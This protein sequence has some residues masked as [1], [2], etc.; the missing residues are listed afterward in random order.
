MK[1][2]A[3]L[4]LR[5]DLRLSDNPALTA[6]VR[7]GLPVVPVFILDPETEA[8]AAAPKWRMGQAVAHFAARLDAIGSRLILRRGDAAE[9]LAALVRE[10]GA[11]EVHW[12]RLHDAPSRHR[13]ATVA[14][15]LG[16]AAHVHHGHTL[17]PPEAIRTKT[18]GFYK[19]YTPFWNTLR[20]T[21][22]DTPAPSHDT[23]KLPH[24]WPPSDRLE[25]W[26]MG[27][28]MNRGAAVL[29]LHATVGEDA[30]LDRL[31]DLLDGLDGYARARDDMGTRETSGLSENLTYG[32]IGPRTLWHAALQAMQDGARN[33]EIFLRELAWRDFAHHLLWHNPHLPDRH[34]REGWDGFPWRQDN[35]DAEA[36]RRGQTGEPIVDAAMREMFATGTM[37]NRA[38][39]IVASYLTKH[40]LTDW[41]VGLRWFEEVLIDW[42]P[43]SNALNWQWVAGCGPDASP[44]FRIFNPAAQAEKFDAKRRYRDCWLTD[45][46][47]SREF[48]EAVPRQWRLTLKSPRPE[49]L[50]SMK[51]GRDRA[52]S[53]L[54]AMRAAGQSDD[55]AV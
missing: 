31:H 35:P 49:P 10:T 7:S 21:G 1:G 42:D 17:H 20:Q 48:F 2:A 23:L 4:W 26:A 29:A 3:I 19:V 33:A 8:L 18:G 44:Y 39:M 36:W 47:R 12:T 52:L 38:R 5:R 27:A 15:V 53:A 22:V 32:E 55:P 30:A 34:W 6:A 16:T 54:S 45:T 40:L 41:R 13:D 43:A 25:D 24:A 50:I 9:V 37:H 51:I 46:A 28:A 11:T 14:D